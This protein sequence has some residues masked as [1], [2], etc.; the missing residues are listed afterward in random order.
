MYYLR[1]TSIK[2]RNLVHVYSLKIPN[3]K[4]AKTKFRSLAIFKCMIT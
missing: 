3:K 4:G 2:R 1:K